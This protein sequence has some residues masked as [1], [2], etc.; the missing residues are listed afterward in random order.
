MKNFARLD[1]LPPYVFAAWPS[2]ALCVCKGEWSENEIQ[3]W[4]RG[5]DWFGYDMENA[6]WL[7]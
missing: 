2:A 1:R 5:C 3:A 7:L 4:R 6:I